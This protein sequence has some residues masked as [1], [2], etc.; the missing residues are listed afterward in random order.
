MFSTGDSIGAMVLL[1]DDVRLFAAWTE[2]ETQ[3]LEIHKRNFL[4]IVREYPQISLEITKLLAEIVKDLI[5]KVRDGSDTH[6]DSLF[7]G[8]LGIDQP[9]Q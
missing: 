6:G 8:P 3:L 5:K 4:E 1:S 9:G 7:N 2:L